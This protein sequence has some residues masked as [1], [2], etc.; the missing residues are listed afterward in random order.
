[1][2]R[3]VGRAA[4]G[5][6]PYAPPLIAAVAPA[7]PLAAS[8][9]SGLSQQLFTNLRHRGYRLESVASRT[10]RLTDLIQGAVDWRAMTKAR[11]RSTPRVRPDW[12]WSRQ[13]FE[14]LSRRA[15][16]AIDV[17]TT[18]IIQIGTQVLPSLPGVPLHCVTDTTIVQ[19]IGA[20]QF[21]ISRASTRVISEAI[22]CQREVFNACTK[23]FVLSEWAGRSV[24]EDY[25]IEA[26]KVVVT[27]AGANVT[28]PRGLASPSPGGHVLFVGMDWEQKGGPLL[29]SSFRILRK[30]IPQAR[31]VIV[32]CSPEIVEEGV[33]V[34]GPLRRWQP[35]EN[36]RLVHLFATAGCFSI[37]P[38]FDAF[39]N[40]L[41]EA[42]AFGLPVVA[43]PEGSRPEVVVDQ[44]TGMLARRRDPVE[45][46]DL[47]EQVLS[48]GELFA[49]LSAG[50]RDLHRRKFN[51]TTVT[52]ALLDEMG[53][54]SDV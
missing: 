32:G 45:I 48:D 28:P 6:V 47:L 9:F 25:N 54:P 8:T 27:G 3:S 10:I 38:E 49:R 11:S 21:S 26:R 2:S 46:A 5:A 16:A 12:L 13:G 35:A 1:V 20:G 33:E 19:A 36:E 51:W 52:S 43:T 24:R 42:G 34:V 29:L 53:L 41:L 31:L 14:K 44:L 37:L 17:N 4:P 50:A 40:V 15:T 22:E 23:V 30:R 39:P 18:A 7:D